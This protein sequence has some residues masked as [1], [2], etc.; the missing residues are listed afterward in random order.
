MNNE[1]TMWEGHPVNGDTGELDI[2]V[3]NP[4]IVALDKQD[5]IQVL[6][7]EGEAYI[8]SGVGAKLGDAFTAAVE[9]MPC[10]KEAV[11]DVVVSLQYGDKDFSM[12][13]LT[14]LNTYFESLGEDVNIIWGSTR[15]DNL[16]GTVKVVMLVN[17]RR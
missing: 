1:V 7:E 15:N 2:I 12:S 4:G 16:S 8:V 13:E 11:R 6:E 10:P 5:L 14:T 9:A 3:A 17:V